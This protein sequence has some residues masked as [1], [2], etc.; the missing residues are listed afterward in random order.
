MVGSSDTRRNQ[1]RQKFNQD[2]WKFGV[3]VAFSGVVL[4]LCIF[5]LVSKPSNDPNTALYWGGLSSVLA[6]WLP[7]PGQNRNDREP[8]NITQKTFAATDD[9][10]GNGQSLAQVTQ[11]TLSK[12]TN[13]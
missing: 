1:P 7:A 4:G 5:Q 10:N 12:D 3:Q 8:T 13:S 6:Y 11:T 9:N 2:A